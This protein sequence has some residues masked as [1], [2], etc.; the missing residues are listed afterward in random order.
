MQHHTLAGTGHTKHTSYLPKALNC[1]LFFWR[2]VLLK[3]QLIA[4]ANAPGDG[5]LNMKTG[6][7]GELEE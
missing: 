6:M 7:M 1:L 2:R 3:L 5:G 4:V